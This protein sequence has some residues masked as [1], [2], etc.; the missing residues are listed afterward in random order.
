[1]LKSTKYL[2]E[3]VGS[4]DLY[5]ISGDC[6]INAG[7]YDTRRTRVTAAHH[8]PPLTTKVIT[9]NYLFMVILAQ[10]LNMR[11]RPL[12]QAMQIARTWPNR[13]LLKTML[14]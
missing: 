1:M 10:L 8:A 13:L 6:L 3:F 14:A 11:L 9:T 7:L 12:H 4:G 5:H 2:Y